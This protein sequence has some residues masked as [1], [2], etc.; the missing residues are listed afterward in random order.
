MI[1]SWCSF[2]MDYRDHMCVTISEK[3]QAQV[4]VSQ[5]MFHVG[6]SKNIWWTL[7][8]CSKV[9]NTMVIA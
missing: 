4:P 2:I 8:E 6:I 3:V 1:W 7:S 5:Q 9:I